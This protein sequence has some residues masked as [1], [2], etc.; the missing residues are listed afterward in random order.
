MVFQFNMETTLYSILNCSLPLIPI[1]RP[2][3]RSG[4]RTPASRG[5]RPNG[6]EV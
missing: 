1:L 2:L 6:G 3:I 5:C 4:V